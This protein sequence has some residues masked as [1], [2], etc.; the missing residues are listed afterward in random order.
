MSL[1]GKLFLT[2]LLFAVV[3]MMVA[4]ATPYNERARKLT[5]WAFCASGGVVFISAL[6]H[7][8]SQ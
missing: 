8:W 6:V 4:D 1:A 5:L 3:S 7:I 2:G